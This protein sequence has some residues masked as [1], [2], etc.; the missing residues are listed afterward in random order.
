[1]YMTFAGRVVT[2]PAGGTSDKVLTRASK[3]LIFR[4]VAEA[5]VCTA[6]NELAGH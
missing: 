3:I 4:L 1:M 6:T 2:K 5:G